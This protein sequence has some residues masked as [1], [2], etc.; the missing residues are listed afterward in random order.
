MNAR[1]AMANQFGRKRTSCMR[2]RQGTRRYHYP[3]PRPSWRMCRTTTVRAT[4]NIHE[5]QMTSF[6]VSPQKTD[7]PRRR[8]ERKP[9]STISRYGLGMECGPDG[10][11]PQCSG[12]VSALGNA[13]QRNYI[14]TKGT[15]RWI[16]IPIQCDQPTGFGLR[17]I[18]GF[19]Q[20]KK[21][22]PA[23]SGNISTTICNRIAFFYTYFRKNREEKQFMW[24]TELA[25]QQRDRQ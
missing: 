10:A 11:A 18:L 24:S 5:Q 9:V 22:C 19:G 12:G 25:G 1:Q 7:S 20:D 13:M 8:K 6:G 14:H 15:Y 23:T 17:H 16:Y 2:G 3:S 21:P 4:T